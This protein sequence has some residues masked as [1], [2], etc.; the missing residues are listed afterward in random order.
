M[1]AY[2]LKHIVELVPGALEHV[3]QASIDQE[4]PLDNRDSTIASALSIQYHQHVDGKPVDIFAIEKVA[5]AV[6]LYGVG[7]IVSDLTSDLIEANR[8]HAVAAHFNPAGDYHVKAAGFA[9]NMTGFKDIEALADEA[10]ALYKE[11]QD[12]GVDAS[13]P[14]TRYS[15][16][17]YLHKQAAIE[18]LA[19]R[20]Q[21]SG[22]K[23][24]AKL[25]AALGR[26]TTEALPHATVQDICRTVTSMDKQAHLDVKGF[27]FYREAL[28]TKEAEVASVLR[29]RLAGQEIPYE[30][31][32]RVGRDTVAHYIGEDVAKEM[33]GGPA[34]FKQVAETLPLDLQRV[35]LD[36]CKNA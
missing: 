35:L 34:N 10:T 30:K 2:T 20:Y 12:L 22:D 25:A 32:Q 4:L 14:V 26:L 23:G 33:D 9:G 17:A 36:V 7:D 16:H 11:A 21:A 29:V 31:I 28:L 3:K 6:D 5:H 24:F 18:S 1:I 19:A 27:D 8:A 15:G 13:E